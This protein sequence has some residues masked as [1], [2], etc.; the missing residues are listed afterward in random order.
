MRGDT[1]N[2]V[3]KP[4]DFIQFGAKG[5]SRALRDRSIIKKN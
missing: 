3:S 4:H 1:R 5:R 2:L